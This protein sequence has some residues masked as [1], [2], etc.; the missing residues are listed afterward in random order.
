MTGLPG[1]SRDSAAAPT[2]AARVAHRPDP[3]E[4]DD[5]EDDDERPIGD[6]DEDDDSGDDDDEDDDD[7]DPMQVRGP[8]GMRSRRACCAW[9]RFGVVLT[10]VRP[11]RA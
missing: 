3:F 7:E 6:P 2:D 4:D 10:S 5:D 9:G 1:D 8:R 11:R